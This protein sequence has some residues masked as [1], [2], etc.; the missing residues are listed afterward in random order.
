MKDPLSRDCSFCGLTLCEMLHQMAG[1]FASLAM[2]GLLLRYG[3]LA[4]QTLT[5]FYFGLDQKLVGVK[6]VH[7]IHKII[8]SRLNV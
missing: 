6:G 1:R 5:H 3:F 8:A 7:P 4:N 2:T